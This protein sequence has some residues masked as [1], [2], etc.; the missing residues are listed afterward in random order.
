MVGEVG[1]VELDTLCSD[2]RGVSTRSKQ[3]ASMAVCWLLTV[4]SDRLGLE[5]VKDGHL[6]AG[7]DEAADEVS[8]DATRAAG[9]DDNLLAPVR[10]R[11]LC[12]AAGVASQGGSQK[13]ETGEPERRDECL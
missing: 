12:L 11:L 9:D 3:E 10:P 8:A 2:E 13:K 4:E 7:L 1:F 5:D 6:G